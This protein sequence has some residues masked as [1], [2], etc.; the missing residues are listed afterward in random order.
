MKKK[1]FVYFLATVLL[2][3]P[4][5]A[6]AT[7][8][9]LPNTDSLS[10]CSQ[11]PPEL[12]MTK[13]Q[14]NFLTSYIEKN[15]EEE[16]KQQAKDIVNN[17]VIY[18][19]EEGRYKIDTNNLTEAINFYSYY[20]VI[21]ND[22]LLNVN[23]KSELK[24][25]INEHWDFSNK[26]FGKLINE[27]INIVKPKLGWMYE[28]FYQG[29]TLFVEGVNLSIGFINQIA[30][31]N[32]AILFTSFVNL[33]VYI[34]I[35]YFSESVKD[36]FN[37]N[38]EGFLTKIQQFTTAFTTELYALIQTVEIIL[39]AFGQTFKNLLSYTSS[40]GA[41]VNWIINDDPWKNQITV[42]GVATNLFGIPLAG[43]TVTCRGINTTTDSNGRFEFTI[44][45]SANS[46][47]SLPSKSWYG[48]HNCSITI[49]KDGEVLKR[50][51]V[52]LSYV[53]SGGEIRWSFFVI[54]TR[55][56]QT[57]LRAILLEKLNSILERIYSF[58]LHLPKYT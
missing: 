38:I 57:P 40:V 20:K 39:E 19:S 45:P 54:K 31:L 52:K 1:I 8:I 29:G 33:I 47:D 12:V 32:I 36:L 41:F 34:P 16:N 2:L 17:I 48:L 50:T 30:N 6:V 23:S 53:F 3:L 46:E 58:L 4:F 18:N 25:L 21:P 5:N 37:L 22:Q 9:N 11:D 7:S 15:F 44:D 26:I 56:I 51:P 27:I 14:F 13:E 28:L 42:K 49:S 35:Y 55:N 10:M 43:A 24:Q